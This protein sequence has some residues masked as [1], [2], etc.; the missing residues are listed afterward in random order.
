MMFYV[1]ILYY[2]SSLNVDVNWWKLFFTQMVGI[3]NMTL[4]LTQPRVDSTLRP[5]RAGYLLACTNQF[6]F[7]KC[8]NFVDLRL[9]GSWLI[10]SIC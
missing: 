5:Q 10:L 3:Y 9:S 6:I 2:S 4:T 7:S 8:E 1:I